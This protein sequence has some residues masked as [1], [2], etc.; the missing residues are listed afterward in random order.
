[1]GRYQYGDNDS[2]LGTLTLSA[3]LEILY[4]KF[5]W[6]GSSSFVLLPRP[7]NMKNID[8]HYRFPVLLHNTVFVMM[9]ISVNPPPK[10]HYYLP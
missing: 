9:I 3:L 7:A 8:C 1:M 10:R 5:V 4:I 6:W 2:V